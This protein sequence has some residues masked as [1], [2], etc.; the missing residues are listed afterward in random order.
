MTLRNSS[1]FYLPSDGTIHVNT[2]M[3]TKAIGAA[4]LIAISALSIA[5]D[6]VKIEPKWDKDLKIK[7]KNMLDFEVGGHKATVELTTNWSSEMGKDGYT[8]TIKHDDLKV[9]ADGQEMTPPVEDY[10]IGYDMKWNMTSIEGGI[11]GTDPLHMFLIGNFY[12]PTG[13]LTKD[14]VAKWEIA[15]NEKTTLGA[16]KVETT[17]LGE[18][19]VGKKKVH[20]F[21]QV[22]TESGAEFTTTGTFFVTGDGQVLKAEVD[23][24]GVQIPAAG[25]DAA[26]KYSSSVVE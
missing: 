10:K 19:E 1:H 16:L 17:Y 2:M 20:K 11:Q 4:V 25:G 23:F 18:G 12:V 22:V 7:R 8:V 5:Q 14:T 24:K 6:K 15:K 26:G 21:K 3:P 9:L 13:E